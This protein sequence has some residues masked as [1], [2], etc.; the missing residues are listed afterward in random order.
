MFSVSGILYCKLIWIDE[1]QITTESFMLKQQ[2]MTTL[3]MNGRNR[4]V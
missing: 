1:E 3:K 2:Q 4:I